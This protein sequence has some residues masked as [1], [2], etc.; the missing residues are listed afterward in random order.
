MN[1]DS[2]IYI[3]GHNGLVGANLIKSLKESG[4]RNLI[5]RTRSELDLTRQQDV[6]VFFESWVLMYLSKISSS[7]FERGIF[8]DG[9]T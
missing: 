8:V 6:E 3:A 1:K 9:F 4:Y 5:V 7:T 2:K